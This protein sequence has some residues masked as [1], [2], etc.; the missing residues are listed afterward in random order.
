MSDDEDQIEFE[1][2][3]VIALA[4]AADAG[5]LPAP[6]V[7]TRLLATLV[8]PRVPDGFT[9]RFAADGDWLSHPVP[10][11]RMQVL[12]VNREAGYAML[13][14][15]AAP[16]ARFPAHHHTGAEECFV[17]SG[18]VNTCNR[19]MHAGDFLHADADTDHRELWTDEG[20][21]VI[22]VVSAEDYIRPTSSEDVGA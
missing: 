9:F 6:E 21:R 14:L 17:L 20:A 7:K 11:I 1:D 19:R 4:R 8:A 16:G 22:L 10:G 3:L 5:A 13:L 12:S 2:A 15:D 18:D